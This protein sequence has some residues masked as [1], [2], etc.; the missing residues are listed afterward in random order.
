MFLVSKKV[1]NFPKTAININL[2]TMDSCASL[3][4]TKKISNKGNLRENPKASVLYF[5][6]QNNSL[7]IVH[8]NVQII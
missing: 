7:V 5:H 4:V 6:K 2:K 3:T 8:E 1:N